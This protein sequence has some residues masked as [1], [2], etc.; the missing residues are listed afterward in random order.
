M[1]VKLS[2]FF[3]FLIA[4]KAILSKICDKL[5][6]PLVKVKYVVTWHKDRSTWV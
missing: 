4:L 1:K 3:L 2:I 5:F 6:I